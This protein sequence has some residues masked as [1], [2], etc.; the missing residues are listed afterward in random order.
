[1]LT[2]KYN[3]DTGE[4]RRYDGASARSRAMADVVMETAR[5][6]GC[7]PAQVAISWVRNQ[8]GGRLIPI[9]GARTERQM[10]ENLE[11]LEVE[12]TPEQLDRLGEAGKIDLGFP[13]TFLADEEVH[14]LIHGKTLALIDGRE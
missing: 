10:A 4:P 1:M 2:G 9:L 3:R 5:E 12:L 11:A 6:A 7:A 14:E 13:H 8:A